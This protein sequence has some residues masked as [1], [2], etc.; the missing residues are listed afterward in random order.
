MGAS[1]SGAASGWPNHW[2]TSFFDRQH[3]ARG[4]LALQAE[5]GLFVRPGQDLHDRVGEGEADYRAH[6]ERG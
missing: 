4:L 2:L 5:D 1:G 6:D 3:H